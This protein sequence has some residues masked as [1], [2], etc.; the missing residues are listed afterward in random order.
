VASSGTPSAAPRFE[1]LI[2]RVLWMMLGSLTVLVIIFAIAQVWLMYAGDWIPIDEMVFADISRMITQGYPMFSR[3]WDIKPPV[4]HYFVAAFIAV[5]G[6]TML[7]LRLASTVVMLW[8]IAVTTCLVWRMSASRAAA[9]AAFIASTVYATWSAHIEGFNPV[10]MMAAL[11]TSAALFA[12]LA[13]GRKTWLWLSGV[14]LALSFFSKPVMVFEAA[15]VIALAA[16]FAPQSRRVGAATW[17]IA[18]GLSGVAAILFWA[19]SNGVLESMWLNAFYDGLLYSFEPNGQEARFGSQFAE[20]FV[21]YFIGQTLPFILP[22]LVM[23]VPATSSLLRRSANRGLTWI[24]LGW[25]AAALVGAFIGKSMRR[26]YFV[27]I[28]PP[29]IVLGTLAIAE[30]RRYRWQGRAML[31]ILLA[32][33]LVQS[34]IL[35]AFDQTVRDALS[36]PWRSPDQAPAVIA[37]QP[38]AAYLASVVAPDECIWQWDSFGMV[39]YLADRLPCQSAFANQPMMVG[40]SFDHRR[41]Q[42]E[43]MNEI[44]RA[45]PEIHTRNYVWGY[46]PELQRL[47]DRYLKQALFNG[48]VDVFAVDWSAWRDADVHFS[49]FTLIGYDLYTPTTL[50]TGASIQTSM[51][52]RLIQQPQQTYNIFIQLLTPDFSERVLGIDAKPHNDLPIT[53]WDYPGMIYLSDTFTLDIPAEVQSGD[54]VLVTGF[55]DVETLERLVP[56]DAAGN[57]FPGDYVVLADITL[58]PCQP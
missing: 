4:T 14:L 41:H 21:R 43:Y 12:V 7:A 10:V 46:F 39:T 49:D 42:A 38:V 8:T 50:C 11:T 47:A 52:W 23:A 28:V 54:Y 3:M 19:W 17:V 20:F 2:T 22:L 57:T 37:S 5:L 40:D 29:F 56:L 25:C 33:S 27:E 35:G 15:A 58:Q 30:Y 18:G 16:Y 55:Y 44:I 48:V 45:K 51:T 36:T 26:T 1:Q 31:V 9:G 53:A 34:E 32:I 6:N 24:I 13:T